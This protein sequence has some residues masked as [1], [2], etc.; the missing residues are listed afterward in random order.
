MLKNLPKSARLPLIVAFLG[1]L[2]FGIY[3]QT[4]QGPATTPA[5]KTKLTAEQLA[6]KDVEI[7][8]FIVKKYGGES[9]NIQQRD[10]V[11]RVANNITTKT[12]AKDAVK[13]VR[14]HLL[15]EANAINSFALPTGDVYVTT[16][17]INRM[18]TEGEVAS[19]L[20]NGAAH[21]LANHHMSLPEAPAAL[22]PQFTAEQESNID[23]RAV[24]IMADAG[25]SPAA[26]LSMFQ[27]LTE[28]YNAG[29]DTQFFA[30][31]PSAEGR[32]SGVQD[33]ITK[34]FPKGIPEVL[35]K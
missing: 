19:V 15:A 2:A 13:G 16:A 21:V 35:S 29:A 5:T 12:D 20:A 14:F 28:A 9:T 8:Q 17:L 33:A 11:S 18:K 31:H 30:T 23:A 3:S 22:V 24:K 32:L 6:E 27:I 25:Y 34:L 7:Q 26:M 1:V 10:L 4:Q